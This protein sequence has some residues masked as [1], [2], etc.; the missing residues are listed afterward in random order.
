MRK[1]I[2]AVLLTVCLLLGLLPT[3]ALAGGGVAMFFISHDFQNKEDQVCTA[4]GDEIM[5]PGTHVIS[6]PDN[7]YVE[8]GDD[9]GNYEV[10]TTFGEFIAGSTDWSISWSVNIGGTSTEVASGQV[11]SITVDCPELEDGQDNT[12]YVNA[13]LTATYQGKQY[14]ITG[15]ARLFIQDPIW[16]L[17]EDEETIHMEDRNG[18]DPFKILLTPPDTLIKHTSDKPKG[19]EVSMP[20]DFM[21]QFE[22]YYGDEKLSNNAIAL[23]DP[24]PGCYRVYTKINDQDGDS[25]VSYNQ[26]YFVTDGD[27]IARQEL[28]SGVNWA[29]SKG[30][31]LTFSGTGGVPAEDGSQRDWASFVYDY[32]QCEPEYE[33]TAVVVEEGIT[34]LGSYVLTGWGGEILDSVTLPSTLTKLEDNVFQ[35]YEITSA[36]Y[37]GEDWS[38]VAVGNG[39]EN[40]TRLLEEDGITLWV[41]NDRLFG[42]FTDPGSSKFAQYRLYFYDS[43]QVSDPDYRYV[44]AAMASPN[45]AIDLTDMYGYGTLDRFAVYEMGTDPGN[46]DSAVY[47]V[48][49]AKTIQFQSDSFDFPVKNV[50]ASVEKNTDEAESQSYLYIVRFSNLTDDYLYELYNRSTYYS[51]KFEGN[52]V[53]ANDE[54]FGAC[55]LTAIRAGEDENSYLILNSTEYPLTIEKDTEPALPEQEISWTMEESTITGAYGATQSIENPARNDTTDGG[56]LSYSSSDPTVVTVDQNGK[57]VVVGAGTAIITATAAAVPEKYAKTTISYTI[58][59]SKAPLTI[60]ANDTKIIYGQTPAGAGWVGSGYVSG[61]DASSV[62]G[63]PVYSFTYEQYGNV[64]TYSVQISG[65][66][67]PNYEISYLPG[68]LTVEKAT[69]YAL[70]LANLSQTSGNVSAVICT[71]SPADSTAKVTVEYQVGGQWTDQLPTAVGSYPVRARVIESDNLVL[72]DVGTYTTGTLIISQRS[73]GGGS[74]GS[75]SSSGNKTE[76]EKNPDGSTT[77]T[78]TKPNG[79]VTETTKYPDG[80][81]EVVE[82]K[83]DGTVTTTT[84]DKTGNETEVVENT[85]GTTRTTITNEDGSSSVTK[86]DK[87]GN[88]EAQVKLPTDVVEDAVQKGWAVALPMPSVSASSNRD[89]APTVT[90]DLPRNT[91][92]KVEIPVEDVT[93]GTVAVLVKADGTEEVIKTSLT[94]GGGVTVTLSDG[95]TVKIVDNSC[96]FADVPDA[97]WASEAVDFAAS[98]ELFAGTSDTTFAPEVAMNRAMIVTVLAR[99]E[100]V[101]TSGGDS[102]YEAGQQWAVEN[103]ISDGT[104]LDQNLTREQLITMLWRYVGSPVIEVGLGDYRDGDSVSSWAVKAMAWAVNAG[105]ITGA[106][107]GTLAPQGVASRAQVAAILMRFVETTV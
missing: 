87:D 96:D 83:K 43:T 9:Y 8:I 31:T 20:S 32:K 21:T 44:F 18:A 57:A 71:V 105:I 42:R 19:E 17:P 51:W 81:Q 12:V 84:T 47:D 67:S 53:S 46:G 97:H 88:V 45:V 55:M 85:D 27:V 79:T 4:A 93:P 90:V 33:I 7:G 5:L 13:T 70:T 3:T 56:V 6:A 37:A 34:T 107:G 48:A 66:S 95:D 103:G 49:L 65:L 100:G 91:T 86:T 28:T 35:G 62:T 59:I 101:D 1:R 78:V 30:G 61:D 104:S 82:T 58:T 41:E 63:T 89:E 38:A 50:T 69:E 29:L 23:E 40:L 10:Q 24:D 60:K 75:S 14:T 94:T 77:T 52:S 92:A 26:Y 72:A 64:G 11:T 2:G 16:T 22:V 106:D 74:T 98:R 76:V 39:N 25:V 36:T 68:T 73:S 99:F 54:I 80:A 15:T 102:W